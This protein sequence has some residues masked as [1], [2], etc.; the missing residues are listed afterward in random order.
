MP[1]TA[2]AHPVAYEIYD[3][4]DKTLLAT[5]KMFDESASEVEIKSVHNATSWQEVSRAVFLALKTMHPDD[6]A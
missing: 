4:Q 5:V 2:T 3:D 6:K 1:M